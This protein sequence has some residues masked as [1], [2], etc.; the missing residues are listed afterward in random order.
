MHQITPM[1]SAPNVPSCYV[2]KTYILHTLINV[3][4]IDHFMSYLPPLFM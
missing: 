4:E 2:R 3:D 1:T